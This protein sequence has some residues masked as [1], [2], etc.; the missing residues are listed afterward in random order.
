M[1]TQNLKRLGSTPAYI[2]AAAANLYNPASGVF[3]IVRHI[4]VANTDSSGHNFTLYL[5]LTGATLGGT[6]E[7]SGKVV[8]ANDVYD[9]YGFM[10]LGNSDFLVG[11]ADSGSKLV[12]TLEGEEFLVPP[13]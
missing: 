4:H 9:W 7:F 13:T 1:G 11:I 10:E 3:G 8:N 2:A 6:Q 5:G 12:I